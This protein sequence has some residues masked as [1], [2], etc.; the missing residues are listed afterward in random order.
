MNNPELKVKH[1]EASPKFDHYFSK[2]IFEKITEYLIQ[3]VSI[4][5]NGAAGP[6]KCDPDH[7]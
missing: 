6:S 5:T 4:R 2:I 3:K 1:P 7:W